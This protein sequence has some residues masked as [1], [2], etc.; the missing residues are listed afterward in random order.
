MVKI[1]TVKILENQ[2]AVW[3]TFHLIQDTKK[4]WE[5]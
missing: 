4:Q 5:T 3:D 2:S 1:E